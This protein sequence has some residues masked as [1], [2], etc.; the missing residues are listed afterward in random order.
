[1]CQT[2]RFDLPPLYVSNTK[3]GFLNSY[4]Y[5]F[6]Q[7]HVVA[8]H[9]RQYNTNTWDLPGN[10]SPLM[11]L[12]DY[13]NYA[14]FETFGKDPYPLRAEATGPWALLTNALF[15]VDYFEKAQHFRSTIKGNLS[16][17]ELSLVKIGV[18]PVKDKGTRISG[19]N[20]VLWVAERALE[21]VEHAILALKALPPALGAVFLTHVEHVLG[22][23]L[24]IVHLRLQQGELTFYMGWY[25]LI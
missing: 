11:S 4:Q 20:T 19:G 24:K 6:A 25:K 14:M 10:N 2:C 23:H 7:C 15:T 8:W 12:T 17:W 13:T 16:P 3:V 21:V 5:W 22:T 18:L 9:L 1:M